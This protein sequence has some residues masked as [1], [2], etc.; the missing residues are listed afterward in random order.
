MKAQFKICSLL[1]VGFL[2]IMSCQRE[3]TGVL[4]HEPTL[5][6]ATYDYTSVND[7]VEGFRFSQTLSFDGNTLNTHN[8]STVITGA[9][10]GMEIS[11]DEVATLGRVLFYDNRL[12]KNNSI[13]CASCHQ[14]S[15]GFADPEILS[16]GFGGERTDRNSMSIANPIAKRNF[17]WD[18]RSAS[19]NNLALQPIFNHVEMGIET[20]DELV[21]KIRQEDYYDDLFTAAYGSSEVNIERIEEAMAQFVGSI[22]KSDSRFDEG[23][24][25]NFE[26][27]SPLEKHGMTLFFSETTNCSSCHNGV[28]FASPTSFSNNPYMATAGTTNIGLDEVYEDQGFANGKFSI[29]SLRNI[30]LTAPYMHDGRFSTLREV[31]DHY[32]SGVANHKDL[33]VKLIKNNQPVKMNLTDLD[34]DALEAFLLT[35]TS[36]TITTDVRYSNPFQS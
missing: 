2:F 34:M 8:N 11:S 14:Q 18:G 4:I 3:P 33:D 10:N 7:L 17:F 9:M 32:N 12:S 23:L 35:L 19:L 28:N 21:S 22:F 30:S 20:T 15:A 5:P 6:E 24:E 29:P 13:A 16:Q 1:L 26:N 36:K 27:F 25:S 31:L